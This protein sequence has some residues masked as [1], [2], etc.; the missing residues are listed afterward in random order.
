MK[1]TT[2]AVTAALTLSFSTHLQA[3]NVDPSNGACD[4]EP[5]GKI[6]AMCTNAHRTNNKIQLLKEQLQA[7]PTNTVLQVSLIAK[8]ENLEK[9]KLKYELLAGQSVPG[10]SS[11]ACSLPEGIEWYSQAQANIADAVNEGILSPDL[12]VTRNDPGRCTVSF[13]FSDAYAATHKCNQAPAFTVT[14]NNVPAVNSRTILNLGVPIDSNS[15]TFYL[16]ISQNGFDPAVLDTCALALGC[17]Q[18]TQ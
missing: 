4:S 13:E 12:V 17:D 16:S 1:L 2:I 7:D 5:Q 11:F 8:E 6:K 18:Y 14:E 15:C 3:A 9:F 10:I